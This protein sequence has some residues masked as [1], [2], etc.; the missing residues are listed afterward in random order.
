MTGERREGVRSGL[1]SRQRVREGKVLC[2]ELWGVVYIERVATASEPRN[3]NFIDASNR[4]R[5]KSLRYYLITTAARC[6]VLPATALARIARI[7]IHIPAQGMG[8]ATRNP[9]DRRKMKRSSSINS[10]RAEHSAL[11]YV[12]FS[13]IVLPFHR[14]AYAGCNSRGLHYSIDKLNVRTR[15][16]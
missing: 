12:F 3:E 15:S 1:N 7:C 8:S 5:A 13:S 14:L 16:F 10:F 11:Y 4:P 2:P 6:P 9:S